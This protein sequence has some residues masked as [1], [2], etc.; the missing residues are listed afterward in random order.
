CG[1]EVAAGGDE[2]P[3]D[4]V[5]SPAPAPAGAW[6]VEALGASLGRLP[7]PDRRLLDRLYRD[8]CTEAAIAAE[9]GVSQPTVNKHKRAIIRALRRS[10]GDREGHRPIINI[11]SGYLTR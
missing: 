7:E 3:A 10:I 8:G 1:P 5:P 4:E 9:L 11:R 2:P 6:A